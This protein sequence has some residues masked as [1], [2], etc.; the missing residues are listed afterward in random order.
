M[1]KWLNLLLPLALVF[2]ASGC[3]YFDPPKP[4]TVATFLENNQHDLDAVVDYLKNLDTDHAY[5]HKYA[6][7]VFYEF[8]Y[9]E[10][11]SDEIK[12]CLQHLW[13]AGCDDIT[14]EN[15]DNTVYFE[16]WSRTRGGVSCGISCTL[17][18]HGLPKAEYQ[19]ECTPISNGWFYYLSDYEEHRKNPSKYD[20][21]W[22]V[23]TVYLH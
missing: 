15:R 16:L 1:K 21:M 5:I 22:D 12:I 3:K 2:F 23:K 18:G 14:I 7:T 9:H 11:V 17:N 20:E 8:E 4:E 13:E 10:I 6:E 19:T